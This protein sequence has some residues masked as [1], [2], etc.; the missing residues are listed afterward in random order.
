MSRA[1]I[2][3]NLIGFCMNGICSFPV[4]CASSIPIPVYKLIQCP[5]HSH[6]IPTWKMWKGDLPFLM[7]TV[8]LLSNSR[9]MDGLTEWQID[10]LIGCRPRPGQD[11]AACSESC[12]P[13][14]ITLNSSRSPTSAGLSVSTVEAGVLPGRRGRRPADADADVDDYAASSSSRRPYTHLTPCQDHPRS[15]TNSFILYCIRITWLQEI[16]R[17]AIQS[18]LHVRYFTLLLYPWLT[19]DLFYK[20]L[21]GNIRFGRPTL[22]RLNVFAWNMV[23][24]RGDKTE[25][26]PLKRVIHA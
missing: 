9:L 17:D 4:P 13:P 10:W 1:A 21:L 5:F 24:F 16:P 19:E 18:L 12:I 7:H 6:G 26:C 22:F 11:S 2:S 15:A 3:V 20:R 14:T 23:V 8:P 25:P